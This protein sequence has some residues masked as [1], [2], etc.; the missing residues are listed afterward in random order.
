M[1]NTVGRMV[2]VII[3]ILIVVTR[4]LVTRIKCTAKVNISITNMT[5]RASKS[6]VIPVL[7][8]SSLLSIGQLF[9]EDY[10]IYQDAC[11]DLWPT[12]QPRT[13]RP[14]WLSRDGLRDINFQCPIQQFQPQ[15]QSPSPTANV[16]LKHNIPAFFHATAG[17]P[18]K[19]TFMKAM[20]Y[21]IMPYFKTSIYY[22]I[23]LI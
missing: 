23:K 21:L 22:Y 12:Q 7:H 14:G 13:N 4:Q 11:Q 19:A 15:L 18:T 1:I 6:Y 3:T 20:I 8:S 2:T 17:C 5:S 10:C 16:I 9:D